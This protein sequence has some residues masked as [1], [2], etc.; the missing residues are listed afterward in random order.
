MAFNISTTE[1]INNSGVV[2][3]QTVTNGI[4]QIKNYTTTNSLSGQLGG[5]TDPSSSDGTSLI[6][7]AFTPLFATSKLFL[8]SNTISISEGTNAFDLGYVAAYVDNTRLQMSATPLEN[9]SHWVGSLFCSWPSLSI[10]FNSWGN[11]TKNIDIRVGANNNNTPIYV[12][13]NPDAA[14][15][16]PSAEINFTIMEIKQ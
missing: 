7:L 13:L 10:I 3:P 11:N 12:N 8:F 1:T 15:Q 2:N 16:H 9:L 6:T 4:C 14:G 5:S